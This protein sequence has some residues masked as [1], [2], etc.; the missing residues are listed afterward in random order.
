MGSACCRNGIG[1]V[2]PSIDASHEYSPI[3][4][5]DEP[6]GFACVGCTG[7]LQ[8]GLGLIEECC[9]CGASPCA[10]PSAPARRPALEAQLAEL[11]RLH[12]LNGNGLLEEDELVQLNAKVALLHYGRD[13][14]V[15]EVKSR[16]RR[17]FHDKLDR[18]GRP[19]GYSVF[20]AY[21]LQ[22]LDALDMDPMAQEMIAEQFCSEAKA[23]RAV[24]HAPSFA[25]TSDLAFVSKISR[26]SLFD[27]DPMALVLS[28]TSRGFTPEEPDL[29]LWEA[30]EEDELA[31]PQAYAEVST[32]SPVPLRGLARALDFRSEGGR[33]ARDLGPA[34][35]H[36]TP[37]FCGTASASRGAAWQEPPQPSPMRK[38]NLTASIG[39]A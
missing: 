39:G 29:M 38:L 22:V 18:W 24:F 31:T 21:L 11:F 20:R 36:S 13:A 33:A 32:P 35:L 26:Q 23:A 9:A 15:S 19:V 4:C 28:P 1:L 8:Q 17:L 34:Q 12:D 16:Y 7:V 14:D 27:E 30:T 3:R 5:L 25:S 10:W 6:I 37:S 2:A